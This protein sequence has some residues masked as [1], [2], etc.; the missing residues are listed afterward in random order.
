L[1]RQKKTLLPEMKSARLGAADDGAYEYR[2]FKYFAPEVGAV[3]LIPN[4]LSSVW[5]L[6]G[7]R[8]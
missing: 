6:A 4:T 8:R 5:V 7:S 3:N 2:L 1:P